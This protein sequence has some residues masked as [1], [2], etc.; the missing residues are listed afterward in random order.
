MHHTL[1]EA[2]D[3]AAPQVWRR[4]ADLDQ[5]PRWAPFIAAVDASGPALE[6][7]LTGTVVAVGGLR[8]GFEV[9]AV[10]PVARTWCWRA[11]LGP[12]ALVLD[13]EVVDRPAGGSIAV[14]GLTGAAPVVLSYLAPARLALRALVRP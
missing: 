8:V 7:G 13:H 10:D 1:S 9:L 6:A 2:G 3:A 4:Y 12:V 14:L 5:W 11:R